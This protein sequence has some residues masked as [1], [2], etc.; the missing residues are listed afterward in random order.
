MAKHRKNINKNELIKSLETPEST[1]AMVTRMMLDLIKIRIHEPA[2][3][4]NAKQQVIRISDEVF[5]VMRI[6][7]DQKSAVLAV[8]NIVN[9]TIEIDIKKEHI[10]CKC[11]DTFDLIAGKSYK[12][13]QDKISLNVDPYQVI[14][15]KFTS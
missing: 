15:L 1:T 9:A 2:F 14:W 4:P 10:S 12:F 5:S 6:A 11:V 8:V 13:E 7:V 3:H